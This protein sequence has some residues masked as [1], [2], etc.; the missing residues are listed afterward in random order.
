M[1]LADTVALLNLTS[2]IINRKVHI[3]KNLY[4]GEFAE[5][6]WKY[7]I[8]SVFLADRENFFLSIIFYNFKHRSYSTA[9]RVV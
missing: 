2:R 7:N 6:Y 3:E 8:F 9:K 5:I 1:S 4:R